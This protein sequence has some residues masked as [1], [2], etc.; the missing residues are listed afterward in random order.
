MHLA[1]LSNESNV[2]P[3]IIAAKIVRIMQNQ[4]MRIELL[5]E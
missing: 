3:L 5:E 4:E 2:D 1:Y